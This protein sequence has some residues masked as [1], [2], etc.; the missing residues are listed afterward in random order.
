MRTKKLMSAV[1]AFSMTASAVLGSAAFTASAESTLTFDIRSGG[2][3][4]ITISAEDIAAGDYTVPFD[5]YIPENPGIN[6]ASLKL[7]INDGEVAEDGSFGNYGLYLTDAEFAN[8]YCFDSASAGDPSASLSSLFSGKNMNLNW[9]YSDDIT[10]LADA[11]AAE[12]TTAW[13]STAEWAYT[14]AFAQANLVVPQGTPAGTYTLDIRTE[15]YINAL[16]KDSAKPQY[17]KSMCTSAGGAVSF[18]SVPLTV[19]VEE[20]APET[21]WVKDYAIDTDEHYMII[22]NVCAKPGDSVDVPVYVYNDPGTSGMQVFFGY[23]NKSLKLTGLPA[24]DENYA[25]RLDPTTNPQAFPASLVFAQGPVEVAP[26]GSILTYL[27]FTVPED[28]ADNITYDIT[29]APYDETG[30]KWKVVGKVAEVGMDVKFYNGSIT[31]LSDDTTALNYNTVNLENVGDTANLTLFNAAGDV[32]WSSSDEGVA[33]VDQ[34]GFVTATGDGTATITVTC[35]GKEYTCTVNVGV[36]LLGD[37]DMNGI[38]DVTDAQMTLNSYANV[39]SNGEH[40]LNEAQL[41][42]ANVNGDD[43]IDVED[44][45]L[46]L[47]YYAANTLANPDVPV[48]WEEL[49]NQGKS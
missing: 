13:D 6:G 2:K 35:R 47:N 9:L 42:V 28:A 48:T 37:V 27:R 7:Q 43:I 19:T 38:I 40:L 5:I 16:S 22:G 46:I 17:S 45:Q 33:T 23:D 34:N 20:A 26:N 8:P 1:L 15:E 39:L 10:K 30:K 36:A 49:I 44:S 3:N 21:P 29:F 14:A 32:T 41:A 18:T 12:D 25:Y 11:A 4:E 31:V 24:P